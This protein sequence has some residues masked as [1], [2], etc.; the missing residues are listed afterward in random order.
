MPEGQKGGNKRQRGQFQRKG[1]K[2]KHRPGLVTSNRERR[3]E[4]RRRGKR[5]D[6]ATLQGIKKGMVEA[7]INCESNDHIEKRKKTKGTPRNRQGIGC[8]PSTK[9]CC[10]RND[11]KDHDEKN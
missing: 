9:G 3:K 2:R 7:A 4:G 6:M 10:L 11:K 1:Q 8:K 5:T